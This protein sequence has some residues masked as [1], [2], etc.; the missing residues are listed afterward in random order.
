MKIFFIRNVPNNI[1]RSLNVFSVTP[2][3]MFPLKNHQ[4]FML[5]LTSLPLW[6]SLVNQPY[7][8]HNR[9]LHCGARQ[10]ANCIVMVLCAYWEP[11]A[12]SQHR[13]IVNRPY[14]SFPIDLRALRGSG[15]R[16]GDFIATVYFFLC[17]LKKRTV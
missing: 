15:N 17:F 2:V 6:D 13:S 16:F 9:A 10:L 7:H 3:T 12:P 11:I 8:A 5:F 4:N 1:P 14:S